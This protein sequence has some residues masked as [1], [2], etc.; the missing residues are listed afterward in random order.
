MLLNHATFVSST[1]SRK[2]A[3]ATVNFVNLQLTKYDKIR[4]NGIE[5]FEKLHKIPMRRLTTH[6]HGVKWKDDIES[7]FGLFYTFLLHALDCT[8]KLRFN[9]LSNLI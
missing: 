9:H 8:K 3:N 2:V 4:V 1:L 6:L 7:L 5:L